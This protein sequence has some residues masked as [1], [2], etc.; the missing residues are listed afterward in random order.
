MTFAHTV[1]V[2][3]VSRPWLLCSGS[4]V[5][6]AYVGA[7]P[8]T[9]LIFAGLI[10]LV[11]A[12]THRPLAAL[13]VALVAVAASFSVSSLE[14]LP[15]GRIELDG[16]MAGD[17]VEG[18]YGPY[19]LVETG[20][21]PVLANL[22]AQADASRGDRVRIEGSV[23]GEPGTVRDEPH[24]GTIDVR[25][26]RRLDG[27]GSPVLAVGNSIRDR[28]IERLMPLEGGRALLA[29]FLVGDTSGVGDVDQSAMRRAG[30][31]HFTAVSG[32]NVALFLALLFV[33]A[34]PLG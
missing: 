22:P 26:F 19:A 13:L 31:S 16:I 34:G 17:I 20:A 28:V 6:A 15:S 33:A 21:G 1:T 18:R 25:V 11:L 2:P 9:G 14:P 4:V 3:P 23:I 12:V 10:V 24:R 7:W 30:L 27:P 29:G 8:G 5:C 32:S